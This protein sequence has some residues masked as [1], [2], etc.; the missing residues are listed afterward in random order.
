MELQILPNCQEDALG[1]GFFGAP[2][3]A[4]LQRRYAR[5]SFL[6]SSKS[7]RITQE[8]CLG[9]VSLELQNLV[10]GGLLAQVVLQGGIWT[11]E[12]VETCIGVT[13]SKT[14]RLRR[15]CSKRFALNDTGARAKPTL[16][17]AP[18]DTPR[19]L[20]EDV[21]SDRQCIVQVMQP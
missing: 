1:K 14:R 17:M 4:A 6:W 15:N 16:A 13:N 3:P 10:C 9:R 12:C 11:E 21:S 2:N 20:D 18:S 19:M 7:C 8:M 5:E